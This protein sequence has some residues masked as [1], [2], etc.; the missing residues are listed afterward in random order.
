M[1]VTAGITWEEWAAQSAERA[2]KAEKE[3]MAAEEVRI[4]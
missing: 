2:D 4:Y 1:P 3:R